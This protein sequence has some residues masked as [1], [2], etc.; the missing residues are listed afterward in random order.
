MDPAS[1]PERLDNVHELQ[2]LRLTANTDTRSKELGWLTTD[3]PQSVRVLEVIARSRE[4]GI[5]Q[6]KIAAETGLD[7]KLGTD[8]IFSHTEQSPA[9]PHLLP[10]SIYHRR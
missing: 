5:L 8:H 7:A 9:Q 1:L 4:K 6:N 10:I 2:R 3:T